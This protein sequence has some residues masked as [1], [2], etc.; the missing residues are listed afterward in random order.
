MVPIKIWPIEPYRK[1]GGCLILI[2]MKRISHSPWTLTQFKINIV[3]KKIKRKK[4]PTKSKTQKGGLGKK[5]YHS[6]GL[7]TRNNGQ[8]ESY[9]FKRKC[10]KTAMYEPN[11][12]QRTRRFNDSLPDV[13]K[14]DNMML[15]KSEEEWDFENSVSN[16]DET[17]STFSVSTNILTSISERVKRPN[18]SMNQAWESFLNA[19]DH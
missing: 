17:R 7:K 15:E 9:R 3:P 10:K 6:V 13:I 4:D 18:Q 2:T 19:S 16:H 8:G 1:E 12:K 5:G 11:P 14:V